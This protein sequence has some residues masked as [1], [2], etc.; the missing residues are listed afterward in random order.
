MIQLLLLLVHLLAHLNQGCKVEFTRKEL[1]RGMTSR[2]QRGAR[3]QDILGIPGIKCA[4]FTQNNYPMLMLWP[5]AVTPRVTLFG[6]LALSPG[7]S[8]SPFSLIGNWTHCDWGTGDTFRQVNDNRLWCKN[9]PLPHQVR[10]R[11]R[12]RHQFIKRLETV[13]SL[14]ECEQECLNER[15]FKC[16][17]FNYM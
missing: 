9:Q 15:A 13:N 2:G 5:L 7:Q 14:Y 1:G 10:S 4:F 11:T 8:F 3:N 6:A 16:L 17:S 12:L